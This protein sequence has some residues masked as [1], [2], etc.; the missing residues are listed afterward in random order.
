MKIN[1]EILIVLVAKIINWLLK[2]FSMCNK[3]QFYMKTEVNKAF[4][5]L[6][7]L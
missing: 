1:T 3:I 7:T 4:T 5:Y 6:D 2:V